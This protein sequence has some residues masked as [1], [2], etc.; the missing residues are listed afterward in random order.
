MSNFD[1]DDYEFGT[2]VQGAERERH[3][4]IWGDMRS[5]GL[6]VRLEDAT[7]LEA[8]DFPCLQAALLLRRQARCKLGDDSWRGVVTEWREQLSG[9][10]F[11]TVWYVP[12]L[13]SLFFETTLKASDRILEPETKQLKDLKVSNRFK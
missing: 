10:P 6:M 4:G 8:A 13:V 5:Q 9:P 3:R 1:D 12:Q 11:V 7:D 2:H